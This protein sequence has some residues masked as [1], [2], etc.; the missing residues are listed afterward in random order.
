MNGNKIDI[1]KE[2]CFVVDHSA[3]F[4]DD[5]G[6]RLELDTSQKNK[7]VLSFLSAIQKTIWTCIVEGVVEYCRVI[8]DIFL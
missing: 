6:A 2:T 5:S 7:N 8:Y 4:L 3:S 1:C